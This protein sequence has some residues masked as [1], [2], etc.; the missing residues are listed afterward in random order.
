MISNPDMLS[1][2]REDYKRLY[3]G[4]EFCSHLIPGTED[5]SRILDFVQAK[6]LT[7]SLVSGYATNRDIV[8]YEKLLDIL[9]K[10]KIE[11]EL[12]IN[13]WGILEFSRGF[14]VRP[15]LGRLLSKQKKDPQILNVFDRLPEIAKKRYRNTAINESFISF[16]AKNNI[17]RI[18][19]DNLLQGIELDDNAGEDLSFSLY[20]PYAYITTTRLCPFSAC[21]RP[22]GNALSVPLKC[23]K[24]CKDRHS[25]MSH[26][27]L[28]RSLILKG[29]TV[30]YKQEDIEWLRENER[31]NRVVF[32]P[33]IT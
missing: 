16:L 15:V 29:N 4:N 23:L 7:F 14:P 13:D 30:Y 32:Q 10:R 9:V 20:T 22:A 18:E 12:I 25:I 28:P 26:P 1:F 3:F 24:E 31:V 11:S 6:G 2:W 19:F 17:R 21:N 33:P 8:K 5:L 27:N